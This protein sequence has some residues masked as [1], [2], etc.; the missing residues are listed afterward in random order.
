MQLLDPFKINFYYGKYIQQIFWT[1][2]LCLIYLKASLIAKNFKQ[3]NNLFY[4]QL[5]IIDFISSFS[6]F[7]N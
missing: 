6:I 4:I 1:I 3:L 7:G 2:F 5:S